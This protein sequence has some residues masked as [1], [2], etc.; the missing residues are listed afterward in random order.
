MKNNYAPIAKTKIEL[1]DIFRNNTNM[2]GRLSNEQWKVVNAINNCRTSALG[3]HVRIC[4]TCSYQEQSYNSCRNRHCPKCGA[5]ERSKWIQKRLLEL[6]PLPYFHLVF[7]MPSQIN[8]IVMFNKKSLYDLLFK[9]VKETL[10]EAGEHPD[11]IGGK[12]GFLA[13]LHTWGQNLDYHPHLHCIVPGGALDGEK[14]IAC[15]KDF[16]VHVKKLSRLYRGKFLYYLKKLYKNNHLKNTI[17]KQEFKNL[18]NHLYKKEWVVYAK[19]PF[20][21]PVCVFKYL[22]N[23]TH[24]IAISNHRLLSVKE[25]KV[26]FKWKDYRNGKK[27]VMSLLTKEFMRR[28]LMHVLP[29]RF[30]KIR[31]FGLFSNRVKAKNIILCRKKIKNPIFEA[32]IEKSIKSFEQEFMSLATQSVEKEIKCKNC[33][34]GQ[35]ITKEIF[36]FYIS[37]P[38]IISSA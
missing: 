26:Y 5:R 2:L 23:Y 1:A 38:A 10:L 15:K 30:V 29:N 36:P 28:F 31:N 32:Q 34:E 21:G 19:K 18:L 11:N 12:I 25:D 6:L 24:R 7:T 27:K 37:S 4:D 20:A 16:Y 17:S 8:K 3:G 35:I 33:K 9:S 22:A 14:W 13:V